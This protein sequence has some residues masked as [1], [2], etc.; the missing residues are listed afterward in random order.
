MIKI[1]EFTK[2]LKESKPFLKMSEINA[3]LMGYRKQGKSGKLTYVK[4][5]FYDD[6]IPEENEMV[7]K[8]LKRLSPEQL[9][10]RTFRFRRALNLSLKKISLPKEEWITADQVFL[11]SLILGC[12]I[13]FSYPGA[14]SS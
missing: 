8:A 4:G 9:S 10:Q 1:L 7:Q 11:T 6:L 2:K 13:S 14:D 12:P 3:N 5:L